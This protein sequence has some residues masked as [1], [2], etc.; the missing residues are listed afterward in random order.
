MKSYYYTVAFICG[1]RNHTVRLRAFSLEDA[2]R[3]LQ[4][5]WG[6]EAHA[7]RLIEKEV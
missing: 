4:R 3:K 5:Q 2:R 6:M 7:F 1:R